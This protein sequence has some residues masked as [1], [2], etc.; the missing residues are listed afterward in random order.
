MNNLWLFSNQPDHTVVQDTLEGLRSIPMFKDCRAGKATIKFHGDREPFVEILENVRGRK[1]VVVACTATDAEGSV[2]DHAMM[3]LV[4]LDALRRNGGKIDE[5][6]FPYFP[7]ARQDRRKG[8]STDRTAITAKLFA[9]MVQTTVPELKNLATVEPHT[10]YLEGFFDCTFDRIKVL[11][12]FVNDVRSFFPDADRIVVASPDVGG[13][14]RASAFAT[15]LGAPRPIAYVD[16]RRPGPGLS[17]ALQLIGS[18]QGA[19][20]V[21][22]DDILDTAGSISECVRIIREHGAERILV[23]AVHGLNNGPAI[24]RLLACELTGI[25]YSN[26]VTQRPEVETLPGSRILHIGGFVAEAIHRLIT[27][28]SLRSLGNPDPIAR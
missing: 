4:L 25:M 24:E 17:K 5:I 19:D 18:V 1:C 26:S 2:N 11:K 23:I 9:K 14:D 12:A 3:T 16:K 22:V 15:E 28:G 21:I 6:V 7:Y 10:V 8:A 20:V 13:R 27:Q